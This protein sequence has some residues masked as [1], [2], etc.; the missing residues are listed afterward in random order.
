MEKVIANLQPT[1]YD[2]HIENTVGDYKVTGSIRVSREKALETMEGTVSNGEGEYFGRFS[3]NGG[4]AIL[5]PDGSSRRTFNLNDIPVDS[6]SAVIEAVNT[7]LEKVL[8]ELA[9]P[10][11]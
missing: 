4:P 6:H 3:L 7:T 9:N 8:S 2:S 1:G 5:G 11:E 10:E